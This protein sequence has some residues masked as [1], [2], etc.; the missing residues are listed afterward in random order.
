[1]G[2]TPAQ[3]LAPTSDRLKA[4]NLS[5]VVLA[6]EEMYV[7][8][9][10]VQHVERSS[11]DWPQYILWCN[12]SMW[13]PGLCSLSTQ[14]HSAEQI[15]YLSVLSSTLTLEVPCEIPQ[16]RQLVTAASLQSIADL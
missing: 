8:G 5:S 11:P 14:S 6:L 4:N 9:S 2:L 7:T 15:L 16:S 13:Y 10:L 1:M 12:V 3:S